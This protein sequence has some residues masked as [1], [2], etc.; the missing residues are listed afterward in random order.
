V[1]SDPSK[2]SRR[3]VLHALWRWRWALAALGAAAVTTPI[4]AVNAPQDVRIPSVKER[5]APAVAVFSHW[6]HHA[7]HCYSCHPTAFPQARVAFTHQQMREGAY[8]GTCHDGR[9][10]KAVSAM[11]CEACHGR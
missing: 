8:C 7:L 1:S 10:A 9:G 11:K 2:T 6:E 5:T 3:G 4:L